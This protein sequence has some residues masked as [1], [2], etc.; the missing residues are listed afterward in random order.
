MWSEAGVPPGGAPTRIIEYRDRIQNGNLLETA[1]AAT[2]R[3]SSAPDASTVPPGLSAQLL[4]LQLWIDEHAPNLRGLKSG[5]LK[6]SADAQVATREIVARIDG[7][8]EVVRRGTLAL[9]AGQLCPSPMQ[10]LTFRA[11]RRY[12]VRRSV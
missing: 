11:R 2:T 12:H 4:V 1:A 7:H 6:F 9:T 3:A 5:P 10:T 8:D